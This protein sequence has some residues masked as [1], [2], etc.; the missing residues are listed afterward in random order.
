MAACNHLC[1]MLVWGMRSL[2]GIFLV[3]FTAFLLSCSRQPVYPAAEVRGEDAMIAVSRLVPETPLFS[4]YHHNGRNI[5][6]FVL[7][8][9]GKLVSFLDACA[10]CYK[11]KLGYRYDQKD[12]V[13]TCRYCGIRFSL[14]KLEKG[15]GGCYPIRIEGRL[16]N[17]AYLIPLKNLQAAADKF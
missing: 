4:T 3:L 8:V 13:V 16:E 5:S 15:L 17:D 2:P 6:F 12:G 14:Y 11:H 7:R 10:S 1:R 9:D